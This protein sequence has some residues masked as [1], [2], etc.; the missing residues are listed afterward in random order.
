MIS[1]SSFPWILWEWMKLCIK[2]SESLK[3]NLVDKEHQSIFHS[4]VG[5]SQSWTSSRIL[6]GPPHRNAVSP[7]TGKGQKARTWL[8]NP[9]AAS[10]KSRDCLIP[11]P[12]LKHHPFLIQQ[13]CCLPNSHPTQSLPLQLVAEAHMWRWFLSMKCRN[14]PEALCSSLTG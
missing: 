7:P 11:D 4:L 3:C 1:I 12:V 8:C 13:H 5:N 2:R 6:E 10:A 9:K 14:V